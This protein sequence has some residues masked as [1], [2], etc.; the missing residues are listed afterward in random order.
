[1]SVW[2]DKRLKCWRYRFQHL[3]T[4]YTGSKFKTR[5][6]GESARSK[7][8]TEL[9]EA[10]AQT[11]MVFSDLAHRYLDYAER[12]FATGTYKYKSFVTL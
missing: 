10:A 5:R 11:V 1:M 2:F 7:R 6:E 8:R 9:R 12:R 3:G 4:T